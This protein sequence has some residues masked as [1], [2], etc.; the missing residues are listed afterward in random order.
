M[1]MTKCTSKH[2]EVAGD[3]HSF[4]AGTRL[5]FQRKV[6]QRTESPSFV[7]CNI[8]G[9]WPRFRM[10][11]CLYAG[12]GST[13]QTADVSIMRLSTHHAFKN[14]RKKTKTVFS[15]LNFNRTVFQVVWRYSKN[16]NLYLMMYFLAAEFIVHTS[17]YLQVL[18]C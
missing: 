17:S 1:A 4:G 11:E 2:C 8:I 3:P 7:K 14:G 15:C 5:G 16:K 12:E 6:R 13:C 18:V 10:M 9:A